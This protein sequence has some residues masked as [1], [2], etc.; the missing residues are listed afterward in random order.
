[1]YCSGIDEATIKATL[2]AKFK[3][4]DK[5]WYNHKLKEVSEERKK[6]SEK[7]SINGRVGQF[8]KR[9]K[10][11]LSAKDFK[12]LQAQISETTSNNT[13]LLTEWI[14]QF[15]TPKAM[16]AAMLKHLANGDAIENENIIKDEKGII[17]EKEKPKKPKKAPA[18][19]PE[20]QIPWETETFKT[21]W[22]HWKIYKKKDHKFNY[23]STQ[24][25]Q[26]A[27]E[28][29]CELSGGTEKTAI[30]IIHQSMSNGWKGFF[31]LKNQNN[32][33]YSKTKYQASD[34]LKRRIAEKMGA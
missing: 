12:K 3:L 21:Q 20:V 4:C 2:Q 8:F 28:K 26:A 15:K 29:L 1:M 32:G 19:N 17:M 33:K 13:E 11:D 31:E 22:E 24:S 7:Q 30:A 34:D 14:D 16:L 27:L 6:F 25:E 10:K 9:A 5:G 18:P 23:K